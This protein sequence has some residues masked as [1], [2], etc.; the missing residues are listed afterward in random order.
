MVS[1]TFPCCSAGLLLVRSLGRKGFVLWELLQR[2]IRASSSALL[3]AALNRLAGSA[4][5]LLA[6][7]AASSSGTHCRC[8]HSRGSL[9][10]KKTLH[11]ATFAPTSGS[12]LPANLLSTSVP[13]TTGACKKLQMPCC[14]PALGSTVS[15][16]PVL[17]APVRL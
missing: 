14:M 5:G 7:G 13:F 15:G 8:L 9:A 12:H 3:M 16:S 1:S 2:Q 4:P 17:P 6:Q 11:T 10:A